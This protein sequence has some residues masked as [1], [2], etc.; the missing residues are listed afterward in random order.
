MVAH[1]KIGNFLKDYQQAINPNEKKKIVQKIQSFI[2][3]SDNNKFLK[4]AYREQK[5]TI[6]NILGKNISNQMT[7]GLKKDKWLLITPIIITFSIL[8]LLLAATMI[9]R[10]R[11]DNFNI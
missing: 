8:I 11:K 2:V 1:K 5:T 6:D 7:N 3:E 10:K 9:V 4:N